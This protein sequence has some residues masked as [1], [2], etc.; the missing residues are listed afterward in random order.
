[1]EINMEEKMRKAIDHFA[2]GL[3]DV[4]DIQ[5][6]SIDLEK[7][8]RDIGGRIKLCDELP[9]CGFPCCADGTLKKA[10]DDGF[11]IYADRGMSS[12]MLRFA[13][14]HEI[15]HLFL[16]CGYIVNRKKWDSFDVSCCKDM[17]ENER[18]LEA[19]EFARAFLM[20]EDRFR[21]FIEENREGN[22]IDMNLAARNF[23]VSLGMATYRARQL[24][25]IMSLF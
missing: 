10:D 9:D 11:I 22:K 17:A 14:A 20:P 8:V 4:F 16:H 6:D 15:G 18:E 3:W 25:I 1:M 2:E 5:T 12:Q 7:F 13:I 19:N 23:D 21:D 24:T